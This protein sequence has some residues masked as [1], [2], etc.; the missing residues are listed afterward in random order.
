MWFIG[1]LP[2]SDTNGHDWVVVDGR[3]IKKNNV[4][5]SIMLSEMNKKVSRKIRLSVFQVTKLSVFQVTPRG[6]RESI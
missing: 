6:Y 3:F 1:L 2:L 4:P 5:N